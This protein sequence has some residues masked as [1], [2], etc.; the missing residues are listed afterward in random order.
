MTDEQIAVAFHAGIHAFLNAMLARD[1]AEQAAR[2]ARAVHLIGVDAALTSALTNAAQTSLSTGYTNSAVYSRATSSAIASYELAEVGIAGDFHRTVK[3]ADTAFS[4][5]KEAAETAFDI[6]VR[7]AAG[8]YTKAT[9]T[10]GTTADQARLSALVTK[11][12]AVIEADTTLEI[13]H[14]EATGKYHKQI[15]D[16][17]TNLAI[18]EFNRRGDVYDDYDPTASI[19][20]LDRSSPPAPK[21]SRVL[22]R[23]GQHVRHRSPSRNRSGRVTCET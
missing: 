5:A 4:T 6:A 12:R 15:E 22:D 8:T 9:I 13:D 11:A 7:T 20:C 3:E 14:R 21:Q 16:I 23:P 10:I 1:L 17:Y 2:T 19:A 18:E